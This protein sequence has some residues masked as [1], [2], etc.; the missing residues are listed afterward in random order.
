MII[1]TKDTKQYLYSHN[2]IIFPTQ[3][4]CL[5]PAN[6]LMPIVVDENKVSQDRTMMHMICTGSF[7]IYQQTSNYHTAVY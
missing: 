7:H 3:K 5:T 1:R 4:Y 6:K 2:F